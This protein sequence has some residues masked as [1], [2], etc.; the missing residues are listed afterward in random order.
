MYDLNSIREIT[1]EFFSIYEVGEISPDLFGLNVTMKDVIMVLDQEEVYFIP[2]I[3]ASDSPGV[4]A[5]DMY[6]VWIH[7][8]TKEFKVDYSNPITIDSKLKL[9]L[10]FAVLI[11]FQDHAKGVRQ[12]T[13]LNLFKE[14]LIATVNKR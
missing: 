8:T 11:Y 9:P 4:D 5:K 14:K 2:E 12:K 7:E 10:A 13:F 6:P 3:F 1:K